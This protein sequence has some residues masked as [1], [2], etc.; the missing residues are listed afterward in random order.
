MVS[1]GAEAATLERRQEA[2]S[3]AKMRGSVFQAEQKG[4][5]PKVG[6]GDQRVGL[7]RCMGRG[8]REAGRVLGGQGQMDHSGTR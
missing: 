2:A 7:E 4:Q 3:P 1:E 8:G 5:R 6:G